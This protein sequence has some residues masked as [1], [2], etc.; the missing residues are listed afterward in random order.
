VV[1]ISPSGKVTSVLEQSGPW[2]PTGVALSTSDLYVLE[3]GTLPGKSAS[4]RV[5]RGRHDGTV[6]VLEVIREGR[7]EKP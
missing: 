2:A 1:R 5:R 4:V 7:S 3:A 6:S